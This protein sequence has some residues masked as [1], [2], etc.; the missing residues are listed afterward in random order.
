MPRK[1]PPARCD[2]LELG[3]KNIA[4]CVGS[5]HGV[6]HELAAWCVSVMG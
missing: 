5:L 4:S 1:S 6:S 2:G 3:C